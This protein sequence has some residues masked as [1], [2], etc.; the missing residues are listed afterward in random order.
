VPTMIGT[1]GES[2]VVLVKGG[3]MTF[4]LGDAQNQVSFASEV[5]HVT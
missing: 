4:K 1:E 5:G 2:T 3:V